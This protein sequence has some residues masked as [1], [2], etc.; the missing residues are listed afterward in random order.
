MQMQPLIDERKLSELTGRSLQ[1]LRNE[2]C[3][4]EGVPYFKIG[5]NVRYAIDD[6]V[7]YLER[8][9]VATDR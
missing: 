1:T 4:G 9:K 7:E 3:R 6:V 8:R 2:R 5:R